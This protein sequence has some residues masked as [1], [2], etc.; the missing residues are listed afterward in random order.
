M[1]TGEFFIAREGGSRFGVGVTWAFPWIALPDVRLLYFKAADWAPHYL[2]TI[3][4]KYPGH[5]CDGCGA[6][7]VEG[8]RVGL[9]TL[10][11]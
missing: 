5:Y 11:R 10:E 4:D 9:S 8:R 3:D 7:L 1:K 6:F 2:L